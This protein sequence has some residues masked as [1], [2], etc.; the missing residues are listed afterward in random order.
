MHRTAFSLT[1]CALLLAAAPEA[2]LAQTKADDAKERARIKAL[3][4]QVRSYR[5]VTKGGRKYYASTIPPQC[6]GEPVEALSAQ[7]M[8]LFRIDPPLTPEQRAAKAAE[9]QQAAQAEAANR[10]AAR[11]AEVQ[12]RRDRALLQTYSDEQD[13]ERVRQRTLASNLEATA[14]VQA[15]IAQLRARH[16]QLAKESAQHKDGS[17]AADKF[18][19]DVK[20]VAYDLSLQEQLLESRKQE[21]AEI[22]ARYDE[23]RRKYRELTGRK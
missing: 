8:V 9:E 10:E 14:Q 1:V 11:A 6:T 18:Q 12:A 5:C 7:G 21:A 22:N 2:T 23:E 19:Q 17:Q 13:I 3:H 15:R 4:A 20:A 16:A